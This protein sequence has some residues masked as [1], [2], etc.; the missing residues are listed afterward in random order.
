MDLNHIHTEAI[1]TLVKKLDTS[2]Q[3]G[4]SAEEAKERINQ[5]GLNQLEEKRKKSPWKM[6]FDQFKET[7]VIILIVAAIVSGFL[8]KEIETIAIAAIVILFAL[9][10]FVQE[11][12][13]EKAIAALKKLAVPQVKAIRSGKIQEISARLLVPGD[14]ILLETGNI[15]PADVRII[16]TAN[17]KIQEATLTGESEAVD[18]KSQA[19]SKPDV[20]LGDRVNMGYMGTTIT[21]GRGKAVVVKTGMDTELGKIATMIQDV[22]SERTPLQDRL[23]Q[24]GKWLALAGGIAALLVL[25][26]GVW[27]GESFSDMFLVGISI[28]VAVVPEGLPAVVTI[29]LA[30]GSQKMLKRNALIRKLPAVETLGS[31][32]VICSD[33]T[34]TLTENKMTVI[35][36]ETAGETIK[37]FPGQDQTYAD[38][39]LFSLMIGTLCNDSGV[40]TSDQSETKV[41]GEPTEVALVDA[42]LKVDLNK[43]VL[44]EKYPRVG[45][46]PF[47]SERRRMSTIHSMRQK[48]EFLPWSEA[49]ELAVLTKGAVDSLMDISSHILTKNGLE[50]MNEDWKNRITRAHDQMAG[51]GVRLLGLAY[52][53]LDQLPDQQ[54]F[55]QLEQN[56]VFA[57]MVGLMDPPRAAVKPA[58]HKCKTAGIRPVMITGDYPLTAL[59]IAK[60]LGIETHGGTLTSQDLDK[61]SD[62]EL[63]K[64]VREVSVFARVAPQD[65][66][67]IVN[68][69]Q[70][71][72][73]VVAMTG[74][75][76]NDS[77]A[78][79]KANIGVAMGITG[80]DV[81]KEAS[82]MVL[83]D[84]NFATIVTAVEEGRAIF[85][86]LIRFI[87]FSLGGNLGKVL[88]ML[89]APLIGIIIALSPL[90]LLW[91][92][93]LTDGLLGLGLGLEPSEVDNMERKPRSARDPILNK[94]A[95]THVTWTGIL[96]ALIS[97][98][99][100]FF[101]FDPAAADDP[102][103]QT[104]IFATLGFTQIGHAFGLRASS[105]SVFSFTSNKLF[106]IMAIL[107]FILH[108]SV[109]YMPFLDDFFS[110]VPLKMADLALSFGLGM[111]LLI[112]VQVERRFIKR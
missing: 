37:D 19:L 108:V 101:Y 40:Q 31:V 2:V 42:A 92:N 102:Y 4:I 13:A 27:Q 51:E 79:K 56:L 73:E 15:V 9:L 100:G 93:L 38:Q 66:L 83:L 91:L 7:M 29:T 34:G 64:T 30:L 3:S 44:D 94:P 74:D 33:K 99:V 6:L 86:N 50:P 16:E 98:G 43:T 69:L 72:G 17:L 52:R 90:Q 89:L 10:G 35:A 61:L 104:M 45:E 67:R 55:S 57:G 60:E 39:V 1:D 59:A 46:I 110:L 78:L 25:L 105:H 97:L 26:V 111:L 23:D 109:I 80:T 22:E 65:K 63:E 96:I 112:G 76:V 53:T 24:L 20:P 47:D 5:H 103:W 71:Q 84:D 75:G 77:P 14:I 82:D 62:E 21:M 88:V 70:K 8:G 81:S 41:I 107:A 36:M 32:T 12:R 95:I 48:D 49:P 28:A 58:V 18:K 54:D 87:K 68:V 85:D 106:S 11:Y